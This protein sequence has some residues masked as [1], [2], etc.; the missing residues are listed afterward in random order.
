[1]KT[2]KE[3]EAALSRLSLPDL[4]HPR[5]LVH[6]RIEDHLEITSEI[7]EHL[8]RSHREVESQFARH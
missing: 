5:D 8:E 6:D 1:M 3:I 7:K 2:I 4:E